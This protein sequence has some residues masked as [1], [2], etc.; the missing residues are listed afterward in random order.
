M[1]ELQIV[2][3]DNPYPPDFGGVIDVYYKIKSE[4]DLIL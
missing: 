1:K 3:F 2:C 4:K